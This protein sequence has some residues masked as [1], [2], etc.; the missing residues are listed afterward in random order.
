MLTP[1]F[2]I[3]ALNNARREREHSFVTNMSNLVAKAG[4]ISL[5]EVAAQGRARDGREAERSRPGA[6]PGRKRGA[7]RDRRDSL[8][9]YRKRNIHLLTR[10]RTIPLEEVFVPDSASC[11]RAF[12][13]G[14]TTKRT[15]F[16][17]IRRWAR[18]DGC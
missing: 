15:E 7:H 12:P 18:V 16:S 4:G 9:T 8:R 6:G 14:Y 3:P 17:L 1:A 5:E 2:L 11:I 10:T 13:W